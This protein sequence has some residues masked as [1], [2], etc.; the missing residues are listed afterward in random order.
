VGSSSS[1]FRAALSRVARRSALALLPACCFGLYASDPFLAFL[2]YVTLVPWVVLYTDD[3]APKVSFV[4]FAVGI[5]AAWVSLL[6]FAGRLGW[7]VPFAMALMLGPSWL[8]FVPVLRAVHR[9]SG[10]PRTVTVPL[11]W[12]GFEWFRQLAMIGHLDLYSFGY[13][14]ARFPA[15]VQVADLTGVYGVSFLVAA[16]NGLLADLYFACR[17]A[18]WRIGPLLASRRLAGCAAAVAAGFLGTLAYG[19]YRLETVPQKPGPRV[20][21]VQPNTPH[22]PLRVSS[23]QLAQLLLTERGV[24]EGRADLIVWPENAILSHLKP[25]P[26]YYEDLQ[27]LA[28]R[29]GAY[30]LVGA[31]DRA[32]DPPGRGYN[33]AVFVDPEG[34]IVG[35][36]RK[37]LLFPWT[38]APPF[39]EFLGRVLP[40]LQRLQRALVRRAWGRSAAALSGNDPSLLVLPWNGQELRFGVVLCH[41]HIYPPI[42]SEVA[43]L[44]PRFLVN[45]TSEAEVGPA[46]QEQVLRIAMLRAIENRI[47]YVRCGNTGI[48]GVVDARGQ[49]RAIL[50]GEH[51]REIRDAGVLIAEVPLSSGRTTLYARSRDGFAKACALGSILL[52]FPFGSRRR[53][54]RAA[55]SAAIAAAVACGTSCTVPPALGDDPRAAP[56]A[57][58]RARRFYSEGRF[59]EALAQAATACGAA[60]TC[61]QALPYGADCYDVLNRPEEAVLFFREIGR[62]HGEIYGQARMYEGYFLMKAGAV[63]EAARAL[64]EAVARAPSSRAYLLLGRLYA[65]SFGDLSKAYPAFERAVALDPQNVEALVYKGRAELYLGRL[66]EARGTLERAI[67]ISPT[68]SRAWSALGRVRFGL[69]DE[70]GAIAAW[71]RAVA[72]DP[73]QLHARFLL[74]RMAV[75]EGRFEEAERWKQE[76]LRIEREFEATAGRRAGEPRE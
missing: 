68:D 74:G 58:E 76:I 19:W 72:L 43:R 2:P 53:I 38:E 10:L 21:I 49:V 65:Q 4:Y 75:R 62:R 54:R 51:G 13:S 60:A 16:V 61:E 42:A 32:E 46:L 69:G 33:A 63:P 48:S 39:D 70:A 66:E 7:F 34:R 22:G 37:R 59:A 31:L 56:V 28:R 64:E 35:T 14:Q 71:Q 52:V 11:V 36:Y 20:A 29:K 30:L 3:R 44:G 55:A 24:P 45:P 50:R 6:A 26:I 57:L 67:A 23:V 40:P 15:L 8:L 25:D 41:E 27:W 17:E 18:G 9:A 1:G 5:Y 12:T 73:S 47:S